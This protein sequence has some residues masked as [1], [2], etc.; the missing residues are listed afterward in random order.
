MNKINELFIDKLDRKFAEEHKLSELKKVKTFH[1]VFEFPEVMLDKGGFD[2]VIGNP[3]YV[4][5]E[6]IN[7]LVDEI[8]YKGILSKFYKPFD[9]TFDY[10]MFFILRSL[11]ITKSKGYHSFIITNKWLRAEYGKKIREFL[12]ENFTIKKVIDF[13]GI[14]VFVGA[15]VDTMV[16]VIQKDKPTKNEILYNHPS[17]LTKIEEGAYYVKQESLNNEVWSFVNKDLEEIKEYI[18]NVG[19]PLKE[20]DVKIY[21]GIKTGFNEAF[22]IDDETRQKII[23]D[24]PKSAELIKPVLRGDDIERY[25]VKWDKHWIIVI[26]S[27]ITRTLAKEY[28][29]KEKSQLEEII[30][31][32]VYPS[33]YNHLKQFVSINSNKSALWINYNIS[34]TIQYLIIY[35]FSFIPS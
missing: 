3:P 19:R 12:K 32:Q 1:W 8:D 35:T 28:K 22:I 18:E 23:R 7:H 15:T 6:M 20:L 4:R 29:L 10:S 2:V 13:N 24:D 11:Q 14:K 33:V 25:Y 21:S 9:N 26:P 5:Q 34:L 30:F 27:G 17:D 31:K 16:Y